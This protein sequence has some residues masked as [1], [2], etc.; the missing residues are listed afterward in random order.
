MFSKVETLEFVHC[1]DLLIS[2]GTLVFQSFVLLLD[3]LDFAFDFLVP[4]AAEVYLSLLVI[5]FELPDLLKF[6]FFLNFEQ[7]LLHR[8]G[9][10][11]VEDW[12]HFSVVVKQI[13][14]LDLSYL[15]NACFLRDVL[16]TWVLFH[17]FICLN[18]H[19]KLLR[20][21]DTHFCKVVCQV[22]LDSG[23]RT[24]P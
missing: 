11:H 8:F 1:F 24:W 5:S 13:V 14:V 4:V 19:F 21:G 17:E 15:V 7:R 23:W 18:F 10:E 9:E 20:L 12:L 2:F 3:P 16:R 22:Y 6:G